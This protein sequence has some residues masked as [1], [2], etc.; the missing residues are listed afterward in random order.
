MAEAQGE[1]EEA[2]EREGAAYAETRLFFGTARPGGGAEVTEE[3][4]R[5][6]V[7]EVITPLFPDGLTVQEGDGQWRDEHG[8]IERERSYEVVLFYPAGEARERGEGVE[9]IRGEYEKRF[10]QGSVARVDDRV[11]VDF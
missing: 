1:R 8:V 4:F 5:A 2:E 3:E 9:E 10:D 6:F 11:R 7:A